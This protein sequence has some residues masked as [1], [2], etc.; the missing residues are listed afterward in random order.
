M[1]VEAAGLETPGCE[2]MNV[3]FCSLFDA[4]LDWIPISFTLYGLLGFC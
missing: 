3:F 4:R 2:M 1:R